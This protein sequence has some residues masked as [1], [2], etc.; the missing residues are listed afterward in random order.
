MRSI[1]SYSFPIPAIL[2]EMCKTQAAP[3]DLKICVHTHETHFQTL[4][5]GI[6]QESPHILPVVTTAPMPR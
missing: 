5:G 1:L 6:Q 4:A 2:E 3:T